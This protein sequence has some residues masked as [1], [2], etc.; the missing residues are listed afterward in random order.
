[1]MTSALLKRG[2]GYLDTLCTEL[3]V[4]LGTV[5]VN[6]RKEFTDRQDQVA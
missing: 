5:T 1:M 6:V 4:W 3:L 2:I